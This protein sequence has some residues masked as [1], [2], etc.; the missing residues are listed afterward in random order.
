MSCRAICCAPEYVNGENFRLFSSSLEIPLGQGLSGWVADNRK[1]IINGNPSVETRLFERRDQ[2][3]YHAQRAIGAADRL[4][5]APLG[6]LTL[7]I[8]TNAMLSPRIICASCWRFVPKVALL[9]I[10][11]ALKYQQAEKFSINRLHDGLAEMP[12]PC[13]L[14]LDSELARLPTSEFA[15]GGG[16]VCDMK[17]FSSRVN[18]KYGHL[19]GNK[20]LHSVALKIERTCC[21]E[22]D[23]VARMGGDEFVLVLPRPCGWIRCSKKSLKLRSITA[24]AGARSLRNGNAITQHRTLALPGRTART[25]TSCSAKRTAR[26]YVVKQKR[27][28]KMSVVGPRGL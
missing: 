14:H 26:M 19:E 8:T 12:G 24:E 27:K 16:W 5:T 20:V 2:V 21:R 9:S 1:P 13:F 4:E 3:H 28:K 17:R 11:N 25:P 6:V 18:D 23:Y 15:A 7:V 10:E 22:Y